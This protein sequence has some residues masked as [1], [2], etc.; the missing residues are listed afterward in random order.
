MKQEILKFDFKFISN[1]FFVSA[2]N[3]LAFNLVANCPYGK[4]NL[5]IF[6]APKVVKQ[7]YR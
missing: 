4:I 5:F 6:M 1:D 2:K 3:N 7:R